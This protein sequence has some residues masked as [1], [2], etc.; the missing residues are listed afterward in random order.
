MVSAGLRGS[1]GSEDEAVCK[2]QVASVRGV[3][4]VRSY[5]KEERHLRAFLQ[6]NLIHFLCGAS[7]GSCLDGKII[8]ALLA[9]GFDF[10]WC[11][12]RSCGFLV[13]LTNRIGG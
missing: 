11:D 5:S 9:Q 4:F 1:L 13:I 10:L 3:G 7:V 8:S 2:I 6:K 12:N